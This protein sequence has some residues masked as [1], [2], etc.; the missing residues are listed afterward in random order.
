MTKNDLQQ[1]LPRFTQFIRRFG[2]LLEDDSPRGT[3]RSLFTGLLLD[4]DDNKN[5]DPVAANAYGGDTSQVRMTQ[6]FLGQSPWPYLPLRAELVR[7]VDEYLRRR[8]GRPDRR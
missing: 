4:A 8:G 7:W 6:H 5:A 3:G 1:A 2:P